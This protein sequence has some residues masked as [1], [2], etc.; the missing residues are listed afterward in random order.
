M[1]KSITLALV[2]LGITTITNAQNT[3]LEARN[4]PLGTVVTVKGIETNGA[5][6]GSLQMAFGIKRFCLNKSLNHKP[7]YKK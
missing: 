1:K 5:E 7:G 4:M 2:F 3:I 6:L